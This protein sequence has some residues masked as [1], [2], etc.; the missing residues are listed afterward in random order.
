Y[1]L[2]SELQVLK[3][4]AWWIPAGMLA[5]FLPF[6]AALVQGQDSIMLA[7]LL[8]LAFR[9]LKQENLFWAGM[10]LG[11]GV[12]R[13]QL[14]LPFIFCFLIWRKW[15]MIAGFSITAS[16]AAAVSFALADPRRYLAALMEFRNESSMLAHQARLSHMPNLCGLI[17]SLGGSQTMVIVAS[18]TILLVAA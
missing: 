14:L 15:R 8:A 17:R 12:F 11:L 5:A 18:A 6:G 2:L 9:L 16:A 7:L 1:R 4:V 3:D 13:F 10:V